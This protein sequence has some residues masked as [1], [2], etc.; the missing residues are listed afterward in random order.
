MI[1]IYKITSPNGKIYIGQSIKIERRFSTYRLNKN[2]SKQPRLYGS[3]NKYGVENHVF[4]V[5]EECKECELNNKERHYQDLYFATGENSLN[6]VLQKSDNLKCYRSVETR[7][8][9][10]K[11]SIGRK[12]TI[13]TKLKLSLAHTGKKLTQDH[14]EKIKIKLIGRKGHSKKATQE[15][16]EKCRL[17][18]TKY[19]SKI[20]LDFQTGIFYNS[21]KEVSDL[22][23]FRQSTFRCKLNG[24]NPN[25]TQFR[26]V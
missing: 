13:E 24:N 11:S 16:K 9:Q 10:S 4:E 19:L 22:Y 25:N 2:G 20:V 17:N 7:L 18:A 21:A 26:Y 6:C 12:H 8:K 23:N 15:T 5:I 1:G 3:F 14:K